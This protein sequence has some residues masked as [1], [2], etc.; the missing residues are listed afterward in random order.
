MFPRAR[1]TWHNGAAASAAFEGDDDFD[2]R[3]AARVNHLTTVNLDNF[4]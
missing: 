3:V 2:R 1:T 4:G